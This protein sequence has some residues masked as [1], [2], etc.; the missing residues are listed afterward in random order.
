MQRTLLIVSDP[1][2][3]LASLTHQAPVPSHL[4]LA[5]GKARLVPTTNFPTGSPV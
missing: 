5:T 2:H 4:P 1:A 3:R